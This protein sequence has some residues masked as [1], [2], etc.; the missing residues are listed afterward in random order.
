MT[1]PGKGA[2]EHDLAFLGTASKLAKPLMFGYAGFAQAKETTK[3]SEN[4]IYVN[5]VLRKS[6]NNLLVPLA[7]V[8]IRS[9]V[10]LIAKEKT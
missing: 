3:L 2:A 5:R 1:S 10:V 6:G 9:D 8:G 4:V 7:F